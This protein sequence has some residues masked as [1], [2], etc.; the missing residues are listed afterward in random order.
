M[1]RGFDAS[2]P[3][4]LNASGLDVSWPLG[5]GLRG[6]WASVPRGF[7]ASMPQCLMASE[8]RGFGA[9]MHRCLMGL[10]LRGLWASWPRC[11]VA[12]MPRCLKA[13][14]L[15]GLAAL[16]PRSLMFRCLWD[17]ELPGLVASMPDAS[18]PH[19]LKA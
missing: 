3:H 4:D 5:L 19:G 11:L 7:V 9:S 14:G 8:P 12:S 18:V 16:M 6:I 2:V 13:S 15:R 17:W 1:P 10:G